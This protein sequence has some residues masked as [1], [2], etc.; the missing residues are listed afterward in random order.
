[1]KNRRISGRRRED[2]T[3]FD[4]PTSLLVALVVMATL[5]VVHLFTTL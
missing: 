5:V 1:M 2:E 4:L 3:S